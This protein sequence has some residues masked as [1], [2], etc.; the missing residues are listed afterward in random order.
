MGICPPVVSGGKVDSKM[1]EYLEWGVGVGGQE[2]RGLD[3]WVWPSEGIILPL[4]G[5]VWPVS[6]GWIRLD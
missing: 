4:P 5:R 6:R 1:V 2:D 3:S